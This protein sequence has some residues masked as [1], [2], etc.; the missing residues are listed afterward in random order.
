[1]P[2]LL[3]DIPNQPGEEEAN[4]LLGRLVID[5][6]NP[7]KHSF[8]PKEPTRIIKPFLD[9]KLDIA[10]ADVYANKLHSSS[11]RAAFHDALLYDATREKQGSYTLSSKLI[12][13]R[14][15]QRIEDAFE[16]V[17]ADER[18]VV[19]IRKMMKK[20]SPKKLY[21]VTG[22]L[23]AMDASTGTDAASNEDRKVTVR[24]TVPGELAA[25]I[26]AAALAA[27]QKVGEIEG[28]RRVEKASGIS[29]TVS[30]LKVFAIEYSGCSRRGWFSSR[31]D[32]TAL[33]LG[34]ETT[35]VRG[36]FS[37]GA[38]PPDYGAARPSEE[39]HEGGE[40]ELGKEVLGKEEL[41]REE[42]GQE[43]FVE[44][45]GGLDLCLD[46]MATFDG[47]GGEK[48]SLVVLPWEEKEQD[49]KEDI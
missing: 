12:Q 14:R 6:Y 25:A 33:D 37:I 20:R 49:G 16:A 22:I 39:G 48:D 13:R 44:E 15:L 42:F 41:G 5:P 31:Y 17:I 9:E 23:V 46:S 32:P 38:P 30:G 21:F 10:R 27:G 45:V 34:K 35:A 36:R 28:G 24:V 2:Y 7:L 40:E 11:L 26:P 19:E 4:N 29:G 43:D 8:A 18:A 3:L 1:M 47:E